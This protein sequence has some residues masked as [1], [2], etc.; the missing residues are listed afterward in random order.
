MRVGGR[1]TLWAVAA[2]AA[3]LFLVA[4]V[5]IATG[6]GRPSLVRDVDDVAQ[7]MAATMGCWAAFGAA[8]RYEGRARRGWWS[9]SLGLGLWAAGQVIWCWYEIDRGH[10]PPFPS[11]ADVGFLT[12]SVLASV[13]VCLIADDRVAGRGRG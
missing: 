5:F 13:G 11:L 12:F 7:G 1:K 10:G 3:L 8:R 4:L 9:I 6:V 2:T